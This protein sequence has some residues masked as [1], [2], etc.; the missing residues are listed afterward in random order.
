VTSIFGI[1]LQYCCEPCLLLLIITDFQKSF[2]GRAF[3]VLGVGPS[4]MSASEELI[5]KWGTRDLSPPH[6]PVGKMIFLSIQLLDYQTACHTT[7]LTHQR[8]DNHD[9][10]SVIQRSSLAAFDRPKVMAVAPPKEIGLRIDGS[11]WTHSRSP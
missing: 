10:N 3:H 5:Q 8:F 7:I 4:F 1:A 11:Q 6:L 9:A 2:T